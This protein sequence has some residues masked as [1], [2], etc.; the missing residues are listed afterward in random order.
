MIKADNTYIFVYIWS[1][2]IGGV[3]LALLLIMLLTL[4]L[5]FPSALSMLQDFSTLLSTVI[6]IAAGQTLQR[7]ELTRQAAV[8]QVWNKK[9][10]SD[11]TE[12]AEDA[13]TLALP[14]VLQL[15]GQWGIVLFPLGMASL[16]IIP[17]MW[18][19]FQEDPI[20]RQSTI[21]FVAVMTVFGVGGSALLA[22]VLS[23]TIHID[24]VGIL[25]VYLGRTRT[26]PWYTA[27]L[28]A[29]DGDHGYYEVSSATTIIRWNPL[30][31][32]RAPPSWEEL[33]AMEL[34]IQRSSG[35]SLFN[36]RRV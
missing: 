1:A 12:P 36:L 21:F 28:F 26:I 13:V 18:F 23:R 6:L 15:R 11:E 14:F 10:Y 30:F 8:T 35:L 4:P 17:G 19:L 5:T 16:F 25:C 3:C 27:R 9:H 2:I 29:I 20:Y 34:L 7:K 31:L 22:V 32:Y 24:D 33:A